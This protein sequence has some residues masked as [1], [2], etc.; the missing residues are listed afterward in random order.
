MDTRRSTGVGL[1]F[2]AKK[3]LPIYRFL[4]STNVFYLLDPLNNLKKSQDRLKPL[5][6]E[7]SGVSGRFPS[8]EELKRARKMQTLLYFG[9][10]NGYKY[11][12]DCRNRILALFGCSSAKMLYYS[13]FRRQG[14]INSYLRHC[15]FLIGC[16]WD[17]TDKDLD[18]LTKVILEE[19]EIERSACKLKYL[20]GAAVVVYGNR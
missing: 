7:F 18:S 5:L 13:N 16:L 2:K 19:G 14:A 15:S 3:K 4:S 12:K 10:G 9:H 1:C 6:S 17:I 8:P 11:I 20:N